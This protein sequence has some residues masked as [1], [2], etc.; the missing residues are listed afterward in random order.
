[1][2]RDVANSRLSTAVLAAY[3]APAA[4]FAMLLLPP[5]VFL[6]AFYTQ[7]LG[8]PLAAVG[9]VILA[10]RLFDALTDPLIGLLSDR[11]PG[12]FGRRKP[13]MAAGAPIAL[14]AV[15]VLF[16]PPVAP[17]LAQFAIGIFALTLGWT[18]LMLPYAAWGAELSGDYHERTRIAGVREGVGLVGTLIAASLPALLSAAGEPDPRVHMAAL[19]VAIVALMV[20]SVAWLLLAVPEPPPL[21]VG[22][23]G[24]RSGMAALRANAPFRR[25]ILAYLINALANGL[26]ATLFVLFVAHVIGDSQAYAPLLLAYFIAGLA[27]IPFWSALARRIGKHRTWGWSMIG[28]CAVFAFTPFVVGEGDIEAFLVI[29]I[30]SG[31]A[32]G[33]DLVLPAA[34]QAD[35]VD[36]D[37]AA[38]GEQRTGLFFA[39]WGIATKLAFAL[40][41]LSLPLLSAAGFDATAFDA[42]GK[43]ANGQDALFALMLLYAVVPV[44]LKSLAIALVWNFPLDA[45]RQHEVRSK[46]EG[47]EAAS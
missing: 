46:I 43:T 20:P 13:W 45:A 34:I 5:Y 41:A 37:T 36:I 23:A 35:V 44:A 2:K 25:L 22:R 27:A 15:V 9:Y 17:S 47:G 3:G 6:P 11:T 18:M 24:L 12:R 10:S 29:S 1:M 31:I 14:V 30:L 21:A 32:V 42:A 4:A 26:P 40:A 8:L 28:A 7:T 38:S 39:L 16:A 33:A 19:G